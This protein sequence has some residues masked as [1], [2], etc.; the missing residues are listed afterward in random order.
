MLLG[1]VERFFLLCKEG[2]ARCKHRSTV[3]ENNRR[4]TIRSI[5]LPRV[6]AREGMENITMKDFNRQREVV[7]GRWRRRNKPWIIQDRVCIKDLSEEF[8]FRGRKTAVVSGWS[9][10]EKDEVKLLVMLLARCLE[11]RGELDLERFLHFLLMKKFLVRCQ[12][13]RGELDLQRFWHFL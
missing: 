9:K 12:K 5:S 1:R 10:G 13:S 7:R 6:E 11:S 8:S 3:L 2:T 4:D